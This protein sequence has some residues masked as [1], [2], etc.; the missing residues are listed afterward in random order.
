MSVMLVGGKVLLGPDGKVA[1]DP[2]CCCGTPACPCGPDTM[3]Q[4]FFDSGSG[5][6]YATRIDDSCAMTTTYSN[7]VSK[8]AR[9]ITE[10]I[11]I[12]AC[13][14]GYTG[15]LTGIFQIT[16]DCDGTHLISC[17]GGIFNGLGHCVQGCPGA[18]CDADIGEGAIP[19]TKNTQTLTD[20][21]ML[22]TGACCNFGTHTCVEEVQPKCDDDG[23]FYLGDGTTCTPNPC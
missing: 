5:N 6:Y 12:V 11:N 22:P 23:G 19:N 21:C 4:P 9:F 13:G 14:G 10:N 20:E 1:T 16:M 17:S 3:L 2:A 15:T 18:G 8:Y 7:P